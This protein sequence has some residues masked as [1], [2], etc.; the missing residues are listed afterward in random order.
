MVKVVVAACILFVLVIT[1]LVFSSRVH[2][3]DPIPI[4]EIE[5][6]KYTDLNRSDIEQVEDDSHLSLDIPE[7]PDPK[8]VVGLSVEGREI[9]AY[10]FGTGERTLVFVGGLHGGYE[11][12]TVLLSYELIDYLARREA[13]LPSDLSVVVI[14]VANPDGL[15]LVVGSSERFATSAAPHFAYAGE[16]SPDDV[17][18]AGRFN[19]NQVD[20]NRNFDCE[21]EP[22]AVWREHPVNPGTAPFSEPESA[23]LRNF[24]TSEK[25]IAAVFY[26]S[27]INGVYPSRCDGMVLPSTKSLLNVYSEASGYPAHDD[28]S[29][30]H[31]TGDAVDWLTTLGVPALTVELS[32]HDVIE[33]EKN[34]AGLEAMLRHYTTKR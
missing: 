26:H 32:R 28:Y 33:W 13:T 27:A 3:P 23:A 2:T 9:H 5:K 34:K 22:E 20:L 19:A 24:F 11:W 29:Y 1:G 6:P 10:R 18:V 25:P 21:W 15:H 14:P 8:R 30:Y 31:I 17:V 7:T 16:V 4:V 12:N